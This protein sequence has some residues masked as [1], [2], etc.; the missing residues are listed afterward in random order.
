MSMIGTSRIFAWRSLKRVCRHDTQEE[1]F[2]HH[3]G[4]AAGHPQAGPVSDAVPERWLRQRA[5]PRR[6]EGHQIRTPFGRPNGRG[7]SNA[8]PILN[9][10]KHIIF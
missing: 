8:A 10:Y 1:V 7:T 9:M 4:R 2:F 6:E 5:L 3:P